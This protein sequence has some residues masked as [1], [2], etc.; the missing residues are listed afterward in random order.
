ML[1]YRKECRENSNIIMRKFIGF[2]FLFCASLI[3][4]YSFGFFINLK[5]KGKKMDPM[6]GMW[7]MAFCIRGLV[8]YVDYYISLY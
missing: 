8:C 7:S 3:L 4:P 1:V 6:N 2:L 5:Y